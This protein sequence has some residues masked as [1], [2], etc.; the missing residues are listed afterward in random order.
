MRTK[1]VYIVSSDT[2]WSSL[3]T[4]SLSLSFQSYTFRCEC[5]VDNLWNLTDDTVIVYDRTTLGNPSALLISPLS[6]GGA[7]IIVNAIRVD[8]EGVL[9]LIALGYCGV[10]EREQTLESLH[11]ALRTVIGGQLWFSREA[12]SS[13]LRSSMKKSVTTTSS[14]EVVCAKYGLSSKEQKVFL[15]VVQGYTNKEIATEL[16]LGLSTVKTHVSNILMKTGK[17]SRSQLN[18]LLAEPEV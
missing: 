9:G 6:R 11:K 4:A 7:W 14:F 16:N 17:H 1:F 8:L 10:I 15:Y 5:S 3:I 2:Q 12:M 18:T 13:S